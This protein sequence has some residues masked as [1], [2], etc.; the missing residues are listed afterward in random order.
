MV[1]TISSSKLSRSR[2]A[3]KEIPRRWA[4]SPGS[5]PLDF[6][7]SVRRSACPDATRS[8]GWNTLH[9]HDDRTAYASSPRLSQRLLSERDPKRA[10]VWEAS[11]QF[12]AST[13]AERAPLHENEGVR[14]APRLIAWGL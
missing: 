3:S 2:Y 13:V 11:R 6:R 10:A 5:R 9:P 14:T 12:G 7:A 1:S 4:S 8:A